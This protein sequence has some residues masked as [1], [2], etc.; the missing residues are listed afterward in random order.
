MIKNLIRKIIPGDFYQNLS[1]LWYEL[2]ARFFALWPIRRNK[3]FITSYFGRGYGDNG[4]YIYEALVRFGID[5]DAV[6]Q[7]KNPET[8]AKELPAGVRPVRYKSPRAVFEMETASVWIDNSRKM[9]GHK[10]KNQL[11]IQTWHGGPGVKRVE[12]DVE[13]ALGARYVRMAKKDSLMCDLMISNSRFMTQLYQNAFWY[14]GEILE[15]GSPRNDILCEEQ[16]ELRE[17]VRSAFH[18]APSVRIALYAPTFRKDERLDVYDLDRQRTLDAL[19]KRFGGE[20]A[21]LVRLHPTISEKAAELGGGGTRERN[22]T[23]YPDM[24]ELL[25]AS[26]CLITDYSSSDADFLL[27]R[28]PCFLYAPDIQEY[29]EDRG[30]YFPWSDFPFPIAA[31]NQKLGENIRLFDDAAYQKDIDAFAGKTGLLMKS[32]GSRAVAERIRAHLR[33]LP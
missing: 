30:F 28:R 29:R 3:I 2:L 10:R 7:M 11:Y 26:D 19:E 17:K 27:T 32:A 14:Y 23:A 4:K 18:L 9:F 21:M 5:C 20:W 31:D 12:K 22:A 16:P 33:S 24:Q 8:D 6:W 25:A 15:C 13:D 1:D